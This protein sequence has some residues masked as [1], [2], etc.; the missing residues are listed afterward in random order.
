MNCDWA[1]E[2]ECQSYLAFLLGSDLGCLSGLACL[3]L[4]IAG[5]LLGEFC[6]LLSLVP[7]RVVRGPTLQI[8][9]NLAKLACLR[10]KVINPAKKLNEESSASALKQNKISQ[11]MLGTN[12]S[13]QEVQ[14][15]LRLA[16]VP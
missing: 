13:D 14:P 8:T 10:R 16:I 4:N 12:T 3:H 2:L 7:L 1:C 5:F 9:A 6:L 11:R 15:A